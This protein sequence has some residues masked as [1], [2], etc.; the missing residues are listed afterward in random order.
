MLENKRALLVRNCTNFME[1]F[2]DWF[3]G[4]TPE[5]KDDGVAADD[6]EN[7]S[8]NSWSYWSILRSCSKA[9]KINDTL[10]YIAQSPLYAHNSKRT[11]LHKNMCTRKRWHN[12]F[13]LQFIN[14]IGNIT[15][16]SGRTSWARY[17]HIW[18]VQECSPTNRYKPRKVGRDES[19]RLVIFTGITAY[20][21][22]I[23][24]PAV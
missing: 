14:R 11:S 23:K 13:S 3:L 16:S 2:W 1:Y 15:A 19:V 8:M 17:Q 7:D 9:V 5:F 6:R 21:M 4:L 12:C 10:G 20:Q 22:I 24:S 18:V